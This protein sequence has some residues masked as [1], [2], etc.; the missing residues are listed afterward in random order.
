MAQWLRAP[1]ALLEDQSSVPSTIAGGS[2]PPVTPAT[3]DSTRFFLVSKTKHTHPHPLLLKV[4]RFQK[5]I[6]SMSFLKNLNESAE[7]YISLGSNLAHVLPTTSDAKIS[8]FMALVNPEGVSVFCMVRFS[9]FQK[10]TFPID[11]ISLLDRI[12]PF[13]K[14]A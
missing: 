9:L 3:R 5:R 11:F 13:W 2:Q 1:A 7:R 6:K 8:N 12:Y 4:L 14:C 10:F